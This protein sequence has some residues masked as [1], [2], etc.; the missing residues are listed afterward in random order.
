ME[1]DTSALERAIFQ[2]LTAGGEI[3]GQ[4]VYPDV[5]P[6]GTV[7]P[8]VVFF[9]AGGG[10]VNDRWRPDANLVYG[11]KCVSTVK[12]EAR[13]GAARIETLLNDAERHTPLAEGADW[14]ILHATR[15]GAI[16]LVEMV[17]GNPLYHSGNRYRFQLEAKA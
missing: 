10:E 12:T 16:E 13:T 11:V 4:R 15:E 8:Y 17:D 9:W 3:W 5:V 1:R 14:A 2:R 7:R 6:A